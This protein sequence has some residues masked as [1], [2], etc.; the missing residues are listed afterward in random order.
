MN[1]LDQLLTKDHVPFVRISGID[2]F[3]IRVFEN[4]CMLFALVENAARSKH[5]K[6]PFVAS[7][8]EIVR[9]LLDLSEISL[10]HNFRWLFDLKPDLF[11]ALCK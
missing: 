3:A 10:D 9:Q 8:M 4:E 2:F 6:M 11:S 1:N 5:V 7:L